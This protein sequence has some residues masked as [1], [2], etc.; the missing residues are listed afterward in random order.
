M[1][2]ELFMHLV[3]NL[4]E[5]GVIYTCDLRRTYTCVL[6]ASRRD[7]SC[8]K[9][10]KQIQKTPKKITTRALKTTSKAKKSFTLEVIR[11]SVGVPTEEF[12]L[13]G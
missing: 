9:K 10:K 8:K 6:V 7:I 2:E 5:E 12:C 4:W 3:L 1:C 11:L 13:R